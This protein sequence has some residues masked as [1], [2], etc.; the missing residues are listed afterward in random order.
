M[1]Y[2]V[3]SQRVVKINREKPT[4]D[5]L[6]IKNENWQAAARDLGAHA[7][8]LYM[9]FAA[10]A[11]DFT[12]ALSPSA[13]RKAVGMPPQTY[14]DQFVKLLDKGYIVLEHGNLYSFHEKP[15]KKQENIETA[16]SLKSSE[17]QFLYPRI[18]LGVNF[19]ISHSSR[20][21]ANKS[22]SNIKNTPFPMTS[23]ANEVSIMMYICKSAT[24]IFRFVQ[25]S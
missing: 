1:S 22:S 25:T 8:L 18:V 2:T 9:Y 16:D 14:R 13:I 15:Q 20:Y 7:L 24:Q 19:L 6:G 4:S 3:A 5:F 23:T 17:I 10:N 12:L 11:N 21:S